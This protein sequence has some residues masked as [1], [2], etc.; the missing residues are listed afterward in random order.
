MKKKKIQ[1]KKNINAR[2]GKALLSDGFVMNKK[3]G[4][5]YML[6]IFFTIYLAVFALHIFRVLIFELFFFVAG[7]FFDFAVDRRY[8]SIYIFFAQGKLR[9]REREK[10]HESENVYHKTPSESRARPIESEVLCFF[11][12]F[13]S[14]ITFE[15][16]A[17]APT[18]FRAQ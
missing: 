4:A 5:R 7:Y 8:G 3:N 10:N 15:P 14:R 9:A 16:Q 12:S 2:S 6:N 1:K 18:E 13:I 17:H 11:S